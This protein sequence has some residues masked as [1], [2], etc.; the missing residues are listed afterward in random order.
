MSKH[1]IYIMTSTDR[2]HLHCGYCKDVP[3]MIKFYEDMPSMSLV[4]DDKLLY[5]VWLEEVKTLSDAKTR[6]EQM[7][8]MDRGQKEELINSGNPQWVKLTPGENIQL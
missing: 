3:R 1:Y 6:F 8:C 2:T 5:L 4:C 7:I